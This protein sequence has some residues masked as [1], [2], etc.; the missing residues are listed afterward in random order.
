[1]FKGSGNSKKEAKHKAASS[2]LIKLHQ[3]VN[4][5]PGA[6]SLI[7]SRDTPRQQTHDLSVMQ[8]DEISNP[9]GLL[10]ELMQKNGLAI[11]EYVPGEETCPPFSWQV[12]LPHT[13]QTCTGIGNKKAEA[14]G[15]AARRMLAQIKEHG[16][17][18][19]IPTSDAMSL[20]RHPV[21][22]LQ[23]Y[24]QKRQISQGDGI[25]SE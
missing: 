25:S 9:V 3:D 8:P 19:N 11:P 16:L 10:Q 22:E 14:K 1:M 18:Q 24:L 23:E 4:R 20:R 7:K 17:P 21:S 15:M 13:G 6:P 12:K 5:A 2:M